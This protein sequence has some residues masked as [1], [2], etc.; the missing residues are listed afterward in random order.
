MSRGPDEAKRFLAA[1]TDHRLGALFVVALT[2]GLRKGE[3]SGLKPEDIDLD[4]RVIHIRR[5]LAWIKLPNRRKA[6]GS[7]ASPS[8][9]RNVTCR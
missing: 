6:T 7:S 4:N 9:G 5:S 8:A 3:A 2:L 1:A